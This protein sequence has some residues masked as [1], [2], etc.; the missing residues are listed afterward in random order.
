MPEKKTTDIILS[1][2]RVIFID[3]DGTIVNSKSG[4]EFI[5]NYS[6]VSFIPNSLEALLALTNQ[7]YFQVIIIS[8]QTGVA[9]GYLD[10]Y[11]CWEI[12]RKIISAM[13]QKGIDILDSYICPHDESDNCLCRKPLTGLI[14]YAKRD[15]Q[16]IDIEHSFMVGD[17]LS[18]MSLARN[19]NLSS[20]IVRTGVDAAVNIEMNRTDGM[21]NS[22]DIFLD[23]KDLLD[24]VE[25]MKSL[26]KIDN[27]SKF[28]LGRKVE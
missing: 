11:S 12:H 18:D 7:L 20:A 5:T 24:F 6:D 3:R 8:N 19:A 22:S 15:Y 1:I 9:R 10:L 21:S 16:N 2:M 23:C 25:Q 13:H 28:D 17:R 14:D 4:H 26:G 27:N